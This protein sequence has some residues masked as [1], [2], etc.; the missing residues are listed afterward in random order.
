[1]QKNIMKNRKNE[2]LLQLFIPKNDESK[3]VETQEVYEIYF[4][5]IKRH[6]K[7]GEALYIIQKEHKSDG[8]FIA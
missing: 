1:M 7:N 2:S 3:N 4:E 8:K 6:L 5:E